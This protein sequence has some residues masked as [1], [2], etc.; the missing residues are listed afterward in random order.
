MRLSKLLIFLLV[1]SVFVFA[2][3]NKDKK[4]EY[5]WKK[6]TVGILNFS[7]TQF[8]NWTRGGENSWMIQADINAKFIKD[9]ASYN[10]SSSAKLSYG[11]TQIGNENS[12]KAADEIN[13]ETVYTYKLLE[14]INPYASATM[15]SQFTTGYDYTADPKVAISAF[16][17]P[18]F[19]TES[20]GLS[21]TKGE[22]LVVRLGAAS[23][24]TITDKYNGYTD[25]PATTEIEKTKIQFGMESNAELKW[26]ITETILFNSK[27][28][29]FSDLSALNKVDV[30]WDNV[31]SAKIAEYIVVS[32]TFNLFYNNTFSK[33]R[34]IRQVLAVG[35]SYS[36]F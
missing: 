30:D 33:K 35:L 5:G 14:S 22:L 13:L 16:M 29:L 4:P 27:L 11:M 25:D 36:L 26:K 28:L 34:Q 17:D 23:K 12:K 2:Q 1:A 32:Y 24:Q 31:F 9:M 10:W 3:D 6:E 15:R 21:Y 8:D 18:G 19:F 20:I 7:Q